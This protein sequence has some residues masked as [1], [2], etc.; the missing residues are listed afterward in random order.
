[1][2][3]D[4]YLHNGL[5]VTEESVAKGGLVVDQGKVVEIVSTN[6][7]VVANQIID[8]NGKVLLPG[9]VDGHVHFHA[10]GRDYWEGYITGSQ[11]AAAGGVTTIIDMPL[12]GIPPTIDALKLQEKR[13]RIAHEPV[14]DY[15]HWAGLIPNNLSD[16]VGLHAN[17][18]VGFKCFMSGAATEEFTNV[19]DDTMYAGLLQA[20]QL[21]SLVGVH[22]ENFELIDSFEK[23]LH[24]EGR[25]DRLAWLESRPP[26]TEL[27]AVHRA[28]F[29]AKE[30]GGKMHIV[31][32]SIRSGIDM[33]THAK[34]EGVNVTVETCPHFLTFTD[35]D[36]LIVGPELKCDPPLRS[37]ETVEA[38][39]ES[40]LAGEIDTV[41][42]DHAPCTVAEKEE[43][44]E[45]IWKAW[46]GITGIQATLPVLLTE[47]VHKRGLK[48][49]RLV[50]LIAGN[51]ARIFGL[52]PR[53][54]ALLPGSDA[55]F[56]IVD[57]NQEWKM[58]KEEI[59]SKNKH[60]PYVGFPFKGKVEQTY[61]RGQ[62]VFD[63]G[64]ITAEPGYGRL[65]LRNN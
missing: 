22:A 47:G 64:S 34:N 58:E 6:A 37:R 62:M 2:T 52:Y 57:I 7:K 8:L 15:A 65:V 11:A 55:D 27:E 5:I 26:V 20:R 17:G 41:G 36:F 60:S 10:P 30:T 59:L 33:V 43:G 19:K 44:L 3:V 45:N 14:V 28:L 32:T 38:L 61:V 13:D 16:L 18:V 42:S 46:S 25:I 50:K 53:K 4:L 29:W 51:P 49:N 24:T 21:G 54:G 56:V 12:N 39:W 40:L 48:L 35:Q 9:L 63:R 1:M 31:H 23:K